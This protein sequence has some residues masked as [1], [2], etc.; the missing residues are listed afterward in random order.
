MLSQ[1]AEYALRAVVYIAQL[2]AGELA[3]TGDLARA[4]GIPQN[5]LAKTLHQLA[6][7]GVLRSTRGKTGGFTLGRDPAAISL[8]DV[9]APFDVVD[10]RPHCLLGRPECS[11]RNPCPAHDRW[12]GVARQVNDFFRSTSLALVADGPPSAAWTRPFLKAAGTSG[13]GA[14]RRPAV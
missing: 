10:E 12:Q 13:A 9:I 4:L 1:T 8:H 3:R 11:S 6:R 5:Y 7:V 2:P 14:R